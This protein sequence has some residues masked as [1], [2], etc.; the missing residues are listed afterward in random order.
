MTLPLLHLYGT[1]H[2]YTNWVAPCLAVRYFLID[3]ETILTIYIALY[4]IIFYARVQ[5]SQERERRIILYL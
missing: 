2:R 1:K 4:I 5:L 3:P